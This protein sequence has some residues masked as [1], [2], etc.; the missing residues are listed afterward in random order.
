[1]DRLNITQ[2]SSTCC[3]GNYCQYG[4]TKTYNTSGCDEGM[5]SN[6]AFVVINIIDGCV[7][8][9]DVGMSIGY[10]S[11]WKDQLTEKWY[12]NDNCSGNSF[13][14]NVQSNGQCVDGKYTQVLCGTADDTCN[15]IA[16]TDITTVHVSIVVASGSVVAFCALVVILC[17]LVRNKRMRS[18]G[19]YVE[20]IN[21]GIKV[22][23]DKI[24]ILAKK[25]KVP[26]LR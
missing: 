22:D 9:H 11:C 12:D 20:F 19:R 13:A 16:D 15:D 8:N 26:T 2:Y 5:D 14:T 7:S 24:E 18:L 4:M 6:A 21:I 3:S 23:D 10:S 1:M 25:R 17:C